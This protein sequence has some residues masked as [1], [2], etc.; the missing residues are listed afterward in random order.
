MS[1]RSA[2]EVPSKD[3]VRK[4]RPAYLGIPD[5]LPF[6]KH[7]LIWSQGD[8]LRASFVPDVPEVLSYRGGVYHLQQSYVGDWDAL[9]DSAG[10]L[11]GVS[12]HPSRDEP[13]LRSDFLRQH[14]QLLWTDGELQIPLCP[15]V[16]FE[17]E[18]VQGVGTRVYSDSRKDYM[19]LLPQW[20][21]W[22][23]V[24]FPLAADDIPELR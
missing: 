3:M 11:V 5:E 10:R 24:A 13:L 22:G 21:E 16:A 2:I 20:S 18:C 23:E 12:M 9:R 14:K 4:I 6:D 7:L 15:N 8:A 19:F 17:V 1:R